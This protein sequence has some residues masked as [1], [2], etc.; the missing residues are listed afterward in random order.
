M[1]QQIENEGQIDPTVTVVG[2][3]SLL[4]AAAIVGAGALQ[5]LVLPGDFPL[6]LIDRTRNAKRFL[7]PGGLEPVALVEDGQC[8]VQARLCG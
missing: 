3:F 1:S 8:P 2:N 5:V 6:S 7:I 4:I